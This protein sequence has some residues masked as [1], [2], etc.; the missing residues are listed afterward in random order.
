MDE[1]GRLTIRLGQRDGL[2]EMRF[3][4]TGCGMSEEV[5]ENIFEP[6]FTR[7]RSGKGTGLGLTISHLII[8]QHGGEIEAT[9]PGPG[10]GSMF[11]VRLPTQPTEPIA[12]L[13]I[14]ESP[15]GGTRLAA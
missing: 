10:Q 7:S 6:F 15:A 9:S 14:G 12:E 8:S 4:D 5:L 2:A 1:A 13:T 11:V 3:I